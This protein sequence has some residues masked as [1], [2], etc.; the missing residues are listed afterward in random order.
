[1]LQGGGHPNRY[2]LF[3][4]RALTLTRPGGRIG[5]LLPSGIAT[6][7]GSATLRRHLLNQTTI[8][9]WLGFENRRRIFPIHR[10]VRFVVMATTNSGS[11]R[12]LRF[13]TGLT[14]PASLDHEGESS[15]M[16]TLS[17]SRIEALN[18]ELLTIP[19]VT[20]AT[21]LAILTSISGAIPALADPQGWNV[22]F[23]RELNASDDRPHFKKRTGR[24]STLL[25]ILEGKHLAP[26]QVN[27]RATTL[28][29]PIKT[30]ARL[31]DPAVTFQRS[32]LGYR[33]VASATNKLT[34]I[35]AMLPR[36]TVSTHTVFCLKTLIGKREQWCLLGLL[37]SLVANYLVRLQV[38]THVTTAL[39]A[40]LPVPR[41][42]AA[43]TGFRRLAALSRRL[44]KT[45]LPDDSPDYAELNAIVARLYNLTTDH[46][47]HVIES[48]PLLPES[49]R[50][51]CL[52]TYV[53]SEPARFPRP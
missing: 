19:E 39:M 12:T 52:T 37:N 20:T 1:R 43:S 45:G 41:P 53:I 51:A 29:I 16:L 17:R 44:A 25:P 32:R 5:L 22:R 10:S 30:A 49:L 40:R 33:D 36:H 42:P 26:F 28:G 2:Q 47:A 35:A 7:H 15:G 18:P 46:Y 48:F 4:E 50:A 14:D 9:T 21:A 23:G 27:L 6:D 3:V 34:L 13:R 24:S 8:D 11:T 31:L 38:T